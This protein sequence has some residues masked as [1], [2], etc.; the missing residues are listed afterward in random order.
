MRTAAGSWASGFAEWLCQKMRSS[1]ALVPIMSQVPPAQAVSSRQP[2]GNSN[3]ISTTEA[4]INA[5]ISGI[6][7]VPCENWGPALAVCTSCGLKMHSRQQVPRFL[8]SQAHLL[9]R[10]LVAAQRMQGHIQAT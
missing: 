3:C 5:I 7:S 1:W 6:F 2:V 4:F 8:S 10:F 9:M